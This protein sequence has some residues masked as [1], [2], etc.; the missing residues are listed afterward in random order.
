M[1]YDR[2]ITLRPDTKSNWETN[3][4][5]LAQGE[6]AIETDT[7]YIK[8]GDGSSS[9][10]SLDYATQTIVT[11][12]TITGSTDVTI[13]LPDVN[14]AAVPRLYYR[15]G[16]GTGK[17]LFAT[18]GTQTI[19]GIAASNWELEGEESILLSPA[20]DNWRVLLY[21]GYDESG[22]LQ[23]K[24]ASGGRIIFDDQSDDS[25]GTLHFITIVD[26]YDANPAEATDITVDCSSYIPSGTK[27]VNLTCYY[28][29]GSGS[30]MINFNHT[31]P[32]QTNYDDIIVDYVHTDYVTQKV[33]TQV[34]NNGKFYFKVSSGACDY[35]YIKLLGYWI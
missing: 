33:I 16:S 24:P 3:D 28:K 35:I 15:T 23:L 21:G 19:N 18:N 6:A 22:N 5:V 13:T 25:A 4:T 27:A 29:R 10:T 31:T 14:S 17:V 26:I 20:T 12:Q 32:A 30:M 34:D 11:K 1:G 7:G 2:V 9:Y 8:I